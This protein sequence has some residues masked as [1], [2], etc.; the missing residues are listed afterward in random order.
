MHGE[1]HPRRYSRFVGSEIDLA[2]WSFAAFTHIAAAIRL[3]AV[4]SRALWRQGKRAVCDSGRRAWSDRPETA[5]FPH[6]SRTR[7]APAPRSPSHAFCVGTI[8]LASVSPTMRPVSISVRPTHPIVSANPRRK[9]PLIARPP[10]FDC[11]PLQLAFPQPKGR[12]TLDR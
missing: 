11:A 10:Q 3:L 1:P 8:D 7:P 6:G 4:A 5:R 2:A 9:P 12:S